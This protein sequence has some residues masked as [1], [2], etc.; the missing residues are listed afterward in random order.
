[1]GLVQL[2]NVRIVK[3]AMTK[4]AKIINMYENIAYVLS[5]PSCGGYA[6]EIYIDDFDLS[7]AGIDHLKCLN[8]ECGRTVGL[9]GK[10]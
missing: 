8:E 4:T 9:N 2:F 3:D 6:W 1:M 10:T 7:K 5:C